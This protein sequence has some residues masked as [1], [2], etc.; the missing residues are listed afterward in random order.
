MWAD[1]VVVTDDNPRSESSERIAQAIRS[2]MREPSAATVILDREQAIRETIAGARTDD[3]VLIAGK[4]HEEYQEVDG[5]RRPFSD[6]VLVAEIVGEG[7][8]S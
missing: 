6:R 8:G 1:R 2:G 3:V 4:G 7:G 5:D